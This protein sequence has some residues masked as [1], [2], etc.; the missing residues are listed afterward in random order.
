MSVQ[1]DLQPLDFLANEFENP[2][3]NVASGDMF[4]Y[5]LSRQVRSFQDI[6]GEVPRDLPPRL[7]LLAE[8]VANNERIEEARELATLAELEAIR[9]ILDIIRP[10]D[11]R[12]VADFAAVLTL[13]LRIDDVLTLAA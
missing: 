4:D 5:Q 8:E 3:G 1:F 12:R 9:N 13:T 11:V 10:E 7:A 6:L 2:F